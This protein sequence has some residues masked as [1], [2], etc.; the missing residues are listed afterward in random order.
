MRTEIEWEREGGPERP[1]YRV[2][3]VEND[4]GALPQPRLLN[5]FWDGQRWRWHQWGMPV[6]AIWRSPDGADREARVLGWAR[7]IKGLETLLEE[8]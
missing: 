8:S 3:A 2:C 1:G 5:L 4:D 6:K 7:S